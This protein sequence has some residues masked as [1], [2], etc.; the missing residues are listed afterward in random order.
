[1]V[2]PLLHHSPCIILVVLM[3]GQQDNDLQHSSSRSFRT[4][5]PGIAE[6]A[7]QLWR[8]IHQRQQE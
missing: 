7:L 4:P 1:M 5:G 6:R 8:E 3:P 2:N